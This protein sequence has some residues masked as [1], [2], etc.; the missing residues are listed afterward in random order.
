MFNF[1]Q[2]KHWLFIQ[3]PELKTQ[4]VQLFLSFTPIQLH[5]KNPVALTI[6]LFLRQGWSLFMFGCGKLIR[7][8]LQCGQIISIL[9]KANRGNGE[10]CGSLQE[11]QEVCPK[12]GH[13]WDPYLNT[14]ASWDSHRAQHRSVLPYWSPITIPNC[15]STC[16]HSRSPWLLQHP[17]DLP[18]SEEGC[19]NQGQ[20][21]LPPKRPDH[22]GHI[23]T[24]ASEESCSNLKHQGQIIPEI[25]RWQTARPR[26]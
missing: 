2:S 9:P 8:I 26:I 16:T 5:K 17:T 11:H 19:C 6:G 21:C 20:H 7:N 4:L 3:C 1:S 23:A 12:E 25:T 14:C 24:L 18:V 15:S 22:L 10:P 13:R